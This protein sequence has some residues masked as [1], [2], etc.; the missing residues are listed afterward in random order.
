MLYDCVAG[1]A[2]CKSGF[3]ARFLSVTRSDRF[4]TIVQFNGP[5]CEPILCVAIDFLLLIIAKQ[6]TTSEQSLAD[7]ELTAMCI[8]QSY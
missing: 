5:I 2:E 8:H 7:P 6:F 4:T 3:L 1:C